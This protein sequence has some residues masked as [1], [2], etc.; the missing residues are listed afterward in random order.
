M[1]ARGAAARMRA[2][3]WRDFFFRFGRNGAGIEDIEVGRFQ[4]F[5]N[6]PPPLAQRVR[7]RSALAI[8]DLAAQCKDD[9]LHPNSP[10]K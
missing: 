10:N 3:A 7:E 9:G 1:R 8:V 5:R 6:F 2:I 4:L